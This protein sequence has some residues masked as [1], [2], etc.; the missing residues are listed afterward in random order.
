VS[1]LCV[2]DASLVFAIYWRSPEGFLAFGKFMPDTKCIL[3]LAESI[4]QSTNY[5]L[6]SMGYKFSDYLSVLT[7]HILGWYSEVHTTAP[8]NLN[9]LYNFPE[10]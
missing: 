7:A 6:I 5:C 3:D 10:P 4:L 9:N 2:A 8:L 1:P